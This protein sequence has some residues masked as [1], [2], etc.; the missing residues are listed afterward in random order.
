MSIKKTIT[1]GV[2][3]LKAPFKKIEE[4]LKKREAELDNPIIITER[5]IQKR[6]SDAIYEFKRNQ[7]QEVEKKFIPKFYCQ[8]GALRG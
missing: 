4:E 8:L 5:E 3:K 6:I 2:D 7:K 1:D